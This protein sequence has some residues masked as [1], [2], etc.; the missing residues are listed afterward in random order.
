M[1][2]RWQNWRALSAFALG[3]TLLAGCSDV[4]P[5]DPS[6][7][8]GELGNGGFTMICDDSVTCRPYSNDAEKFPKAI[9]LSSKFRLRYIPK[10][11]SNGLNIR[12]NEKAPPTGSHIAPVSEDYITRSFDGE[13]VAK[14]AGYATIMAR[15]AQGSIMDFTTVRIRTPEELVVYDANYQ[16][17]D[18]PPRIREPKLKVGD[19]V[20]WRVFARAGSE[21]LAGEIQTDWHS[22][23][24]DIADVEDFST[25]KGVVVAKAVGTTTLTIEGG[26][27]RLE[28]PVEVTE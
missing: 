17:G 27:F 21:N 24:P 7:R 16:G 1:M 19:R 9:A 14:K 5:D 12:I 11:D 3:A 8:A 6:Y 23:D 2:H 15:T 28:L 18:S 26:S 22:P 4:G 13:L 25:G 10:P 20:S